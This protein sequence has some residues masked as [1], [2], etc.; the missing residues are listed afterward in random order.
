VLAQTS[1]PDQAILTFRT[2]DEAATILD[3]YA[4][5]LPDHGWTIA[6]DA[7]VVNTPG[8]VYGQNFG[9]HRFWLTITLAPAQQTVTQTVLYHEQRHGVRDCP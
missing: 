8:H 3:W 1:T 6:N 4:R 7:P 5:T 2:T 9:C